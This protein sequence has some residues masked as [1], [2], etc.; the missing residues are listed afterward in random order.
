MSGTIANYVKAF[1]S[2]FDYL[3]NKDWYNIDPRC[4]P[5]P[6][7]RNKERTVPSDEDVAQ[8]LSVVNN[9]EDK[10]AILLLVDT[11]IRVQELATIKLKNINLNGSSILINGKG[12]KTRTIY[13]SETTVEH[14]RTY[15]Q[16]L[17]SEYLFPSTRA[18]AKSLYRNRTYFEHRLRD[19]CRQANI[20]PITPHQLRHYFATYTLSRG[21]DIKTVSEMLGHADVTVTLKIYHHVDA[22]SIRRMHLEYSPL[23]ELKPIS[24]P[25]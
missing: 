14:L 16:T 11:G 1:R 12:G 18:D 8:L 15:V 9:A 2:F 7:V 20:E 10:I 21:S 25:A 24:V 5:L 23:R 19:L 17:N 4:L 3:Y 6:K 22:K 13:L